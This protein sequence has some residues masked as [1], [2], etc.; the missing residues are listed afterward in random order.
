M[1]VKKYN[2][3][4][5]NTYGQF[6]IQYVLDINTYCEYSVNLFNWNTLEDH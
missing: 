6:L 3:S 4:M 1:R 2:F 5:S